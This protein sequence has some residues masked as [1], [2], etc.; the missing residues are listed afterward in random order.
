MF[1]DAPG[2][3]LRLRARLLVGAMAAAAAY[4]A[5]QMLAAA[6]LS[7]VLAPAP[8]PGPAGSVILLA[9]LAASTGLAV[10]QATGAGRLQRLRVHLSRG[11]YINL[12]INR[13]LGAYRANSTSP[14]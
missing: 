11:L 2:Q 9:M 5:I 4:F 12:F 10:L 1:L 6:A 3:P 8:V 13:W 7:G 14:R